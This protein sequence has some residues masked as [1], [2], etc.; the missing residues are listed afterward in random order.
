[1]TRRTLLFLALVVL[2]IAGVVAGACVQVQHDRAALLEQSLDEGK[3]DALEK[4]VEAEVADAIRFANESP[5]PTLAELEPTT[6]SGPFA[7]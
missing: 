6:Y 7:Y 5:E 3:L 4:D 2:A 1:M